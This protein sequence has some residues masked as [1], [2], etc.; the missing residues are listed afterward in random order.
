MQHKFTLHEKPFSTN[1]FYTGNGRFKTTAAKEWSASIL[2]ALNNPDILS[3][4]KELREHFNPKK[5]SYQI[6]FTFYYPKSIFF[7]K[8]GELSHKSFDITNCEKHLQDLLFSSKVFGTNSPYECENLNIDDKFVT[9]LVS[10]KRPG[11]DYKIEVSIG[12]VDLDLLL[13]DH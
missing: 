6:E 13:Q 3:K 1:S 4:L 7:N 11:V 10:R 9:D 12:I 2:F 8:S 5:H